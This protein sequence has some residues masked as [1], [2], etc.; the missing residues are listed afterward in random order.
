MKKFQIFAFAMILLCSIGIANAQTT[1]YWRWEGDT[2][3]ASSQVYRWDEAD[4][5]AKPAGATE[6]FPGQQTTDAQVYIP[7]LTATGT[8]YPTLDASVTINA[9]Y[10]E[11][12]AMINRQFMINATTWYTDITVPTNR[13]IFMGSP[14][15]GIYSGDYYTATQGGTY[16]GP[17]SPSV[18]NGT[19]G[20]DG[21]N[22]RFPYA[23][24][25]RLYANATVIRYAAYDI[26]NYEL[27][28]ENPTNALAYQYQPGEGFQLLARGEGKDEKE[29]FHFPASDVEYYYY[30]NHGEITTDGNGNQMKETGLSRAESGKPVYNA[31][32]TLITLRRNVP[33]GQQASQLWAVGNP[34]FASLD[35]AE[36]LKANKSAGN[37][38]NYLYKHE[39]GDGSLAAADG[40]DVIYYLDPT[41]NTLT[42]AIP[43]TVTPVQN[44][45]ATTDNPYINRNHGFKVV[46][47]NGQTQPS[48]PTALLGDYNMTLTPHPID[49]SFDMQ[50]IFWYNNRASGIN[51]NTYSSN[52][53]ITIAQHTTDPNKVLIYNFAGLAS[54]VVEGIVDPT[55]HTI[56]I[57]GGTILG[58]YSA[59]TSGVN[60]SNNSTNMVIWGSNDTQCILSS[61]T[62]ISNNARSNQNTAN[63][64]VHSYYATNCS[65]QT[66]FQFNY[67]INADGSV[68][69]SNTNCFAAYPE[70][71]DTTFFYT[72]SVWHDQWG[73]GGNWGLG[74]FF[75]STWNCFDSYTGSKAATT[76]TDNTTAGTGSDEITILFSEKM[77]TTE[78]TDAAQQ[79]SGQHNLGNMAS[80][81]GRYNNQ[82]LNTIIVRS[83]DA[84]NGY[85]SLEDAAVL[86]E[87][88]NDAFTFGSLAG[89]V[90]VA[91]N[92]INDATQA[93]LVI[94]GVNGNIELTFDNLA[95]LGDNVRLFDANDSTFRTLDGNHESI[96][97]NFGVN[98][99][100]LRYS[101]V[102]DYAPIV[103]G[104]ET[105][106]EI[107]FV[108]F[109]PA[110]GEVKVM[111]NE[112]L[113]NVRLY[114]AAGQLINSVKAN[115][116]E[117]SFSSLLSGI[118]VIEAYTNNGKATK[119]VDVK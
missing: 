41:T 1:S 97:V 37:T 2:K 65:Q 21:K 52:T 48:Y 101:L 23:I 86:G 10:L 80:I 81:V 19:T 3:D 40:V 26:D 107:D 69:L 118:Y 45:T 76:S 8:G 88:D 51:T 99:S 18:Y 98:D 119:K 82:T 56:T 87:Y 89:T 93:Q 94:T 112:T 58:D 71:N 77:F 61:E 90:R 114:N 35:I 13:W 96:T 85:N 111:S 49:W 39:A 11:A 25:Q 73:L 110:K 64:R 29:T 28:W 66:A 70:T 75:S 108:A 50:V 105:L 103:S 33:A 117:A 38:T 32:T 47:G 113:T 116:N 62:T 84:E 78:H 68:S 22:R 95:A 83:N 5:W 91:V 12:G 115:A 104:N 30:D 46:V 34:A 4:N 74:T 31:S 59:W 20:N 106:T 54:Q 15:K 9:I 67:T 57:S 24:H 53:N 44:G 92:T 100:P 60:A 63:Y 55:N 109:S 7:E 14:L 17:F 79:T 16:V 102:W 42:T 6:D 72:G 36:F 27:S 43:S